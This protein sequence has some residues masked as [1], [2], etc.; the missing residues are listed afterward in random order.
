MVAPT[1]LGW[2]DCEF[3][4]ISV[5]P[6][7]APSLFGFTPSL[8]PLKARREKEQKLV[9]FSRRCTCVQREGKFADKKQ[10]ALTL[11]EKHTEKCAF[12]P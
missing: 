2:F 4:V 9:N 8:R 7:F 5:L 6:V 3:Y 12:Q 1:I 10:K 11:E